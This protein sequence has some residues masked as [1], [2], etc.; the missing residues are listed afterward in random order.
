MKNNLSPGPDEA[1]KPF[2][3][4]FFGYDPKGDDFCLD[5]AE[6]LAEGDLRPIIL[7]DFKEGEDD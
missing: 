3:G 1:G 2:G 6:S 7:E 4:G 5:Y